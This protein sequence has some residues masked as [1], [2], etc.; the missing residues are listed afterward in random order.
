LK[1]LKLALHGR[2]DE[3]DVPVW[4]AEWPERRPAFD[5]PE[6]QSLEIVD[7]EVRVR[8]GDNRKLWLLLANLAGAGLVIAFKDYLPSGADP[9]HPTAVLWQLLKLAFQIRSQN[10]SSEFAIVF[11]ALVCSISLSFVLLW[12]TRPPLYLGVALGL[13]LFQCAMSSFV[14]WRT[15]ETSA[16]LDWYVTAAQLL[17]FA[18]LLF[19]ALFA[20]SRASLIALLIYQLIDSLGFAMWFDKDAQASSLA[21]GSGIRLLLIGSLIYAL[22]KL[23]KAG[24]VTPPLPRVDWP[25][26]FK[27]AILLLG[28]V[29][30]ALAIALVLQIAAP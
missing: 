16:L 18:C 29:G 23:P 19:W 11:D 12:I 27:P 13:N 17:I 26:I 10:P 25:G 3:L 30:G 5:V 20:K 21:I 8:K 28:L 6:L 22:F 15:W 14:I 24:I 9:A 4:R 1:A 7:G 2:S